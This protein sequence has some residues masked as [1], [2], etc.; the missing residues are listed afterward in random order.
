MGLGW[1]FLTLGISL[2]KGVKDLKMAGNLFPRASFPSQVVD[3]LCNQLVSS[4]RLAAF[5][6]FPTA[7]GRVCFQS[8]TQE[9]VNSDQQIQKILL[10]LLERI[11]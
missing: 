8:Y 1:L 6:P 9:L 11:F 10:T 2:E 3:I 4:I 7:H 5:G